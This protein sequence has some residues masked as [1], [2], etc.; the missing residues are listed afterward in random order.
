MFDKVDGFR[1]IIIAALVLSVLAALFAQAQVPG[2]AEEEPAVPDWI[3]EINPADYV[4]LDSE[5][6]ADLHVAGEI[7]AEARAAEMAVERE[8]RA[9]VE[10]VA[11]F[12][13][14]ENICQPD[15]DGIYDCIGGNLLLSVYVYETADLARSAW[16][17]TIVEQYGELPP[18]EGFDYVWNLIDPT[19][20][21]FAGQGSCVGPYIWYRNLCCTIFGNGDENDRRVASLWLD[22]VSNAEPPVQVNLRMREEGLSLIMGYVYHGSFIGT[23]NYRPL[24]EIAADQQVVQAQV[25][26]AG[27]EVAENVY[28]Q[29]YLQLPGEFEYSKLGEPLLAGNVPPREGRA[30]YINW[31][32]QGENVEGAVIGAQAFVPGAVDVNPDDDFVSITVNVY[33]AFNGER[34]YSTVDDAYSF[35]NYNFNQSETEE[36]AEELIATVAAGVPSSLEKDLW[37]RL[38]FPTTYVR[39]WDYFNESYGSGAGGH[40]YGMAATSALYFTDPS[41]RPAAKKTGEMSKEE[42]SQNIDIYHRA[43]MIPLVRALLADESPYF[44]KSWGTSSYDSQLKTYTKIKRSLKEDRTPLIIEFGG[45]ENDNKNYSQHAVL[46]YK[47]VEIEGEDYKQVYIYD[48]NTLMSDLEEFKKPMPVVLLW[49][50]G[51]FIY[52]VQSGVQHYRWRAPRYIDAN[53]VFRNIPLEEANALL[54]GLK[55]MAS[56]FIETLKKEGKF[57]AALRCPADALLT[58]SSGRRVGTVGGRIVNE[59][60]G[61]EVMSSGEVEIYLLPSDLE[62]SLEI[63]GTGSGPVDLDLVAPVGEASAKVVS[64]AN[65]SIGAGEKLTSEMAAGGEIEDLKSGTST[66]EPSLSGTLDLSAEGGADETTLGGGIGVEAVDGAGEGSEADRTMEQELIFERN[67][68]GAVQNGPTSP[69][70]F[71]IDREWTVTEI[72]TYHWNY[73][74]GKAPGTIGLQDGRGMVLGTWAASRLPGSGGVPDAYWTARPNLI[75][76]PGEY[77]ILDSDPATW[78]Q[79]SETAGE[80][81]AW[82]YGV[83]SEAAGQGAEESAASGDDGPWGLPGYGEILVDAPP[84]GWE[85]VIPGEAI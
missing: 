63:T 57:A 70:I 11:F 50:D 36:L 65:V 24:S 4:L 67:T 53:P 83:P 82:V 52:S 72:K 58:D 56:G 31:D 42:A 41:L 44:E 71:T 29:F 23:E 66:M 9:D 13:A 59:I 47:L 7:F 51:F 85:G 78:S 40:C 48:S 5:L 21:R 84:G 12:E 45:P 60:P 20:P 26:N 33:Y 27:D 28:I 62:Y 32:L 34:A 8:G 54:P 74:Q 46:A 64:F 79:N 37:L 43:Q 49:L 38:F 61:A 73:G 17:N 22:K 15:P 1:K 16:E 3:N 2:G 80:G 6:P 14:H 69:T 35:R 75:L 77:T 19:E 30:V 55:E 81:I 18:P 68:L 76:Q 39:L 25:F 10:R